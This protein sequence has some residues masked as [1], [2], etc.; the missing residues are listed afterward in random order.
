M[1]EVQKCAAFFGLTSTLAVCGLDCGFLQRETLFLPPELPR[2][3]LMGSGEQLAA[4]L[5]HTSE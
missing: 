4:D 2:R 1:Y 5:V 3:I